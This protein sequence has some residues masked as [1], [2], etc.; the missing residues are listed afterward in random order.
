LLLA[1]DP[2]GVSAFSINGWGGLRPRRGRSRCFIPMGKS[3]P[4][5]GIVAIHSIRMTISRRR[6]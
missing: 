4:P 2:E 3:E 6:F 1:L 5:V